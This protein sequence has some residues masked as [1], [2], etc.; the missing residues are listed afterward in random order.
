[1]TVTAYRHFLQKHTRGE[2]HGCEQTLGPP[3]VQTTRH[4]IGAFD[5]ERDE[6][7]EAEAVEADDDAVSEETEELQDDDAEEA[8]VDDDKDEEEE[9]AVANAKS[10]A[11]AESFLTPRD[12]F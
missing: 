7:E 5:K 2:Q 9:A 1:M 6:D 10:F 4:I 11:V 8:E 3:A 12:F